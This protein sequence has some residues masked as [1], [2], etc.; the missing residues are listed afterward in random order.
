MSAP[1]RPQASSRRSAQHEGTAVSA[2][3]Q[4]RLNMASAAQIAEHLRRGDA[5]FVPHLSSRVEIDAYALKMGCK[6]TRFEAWSDGTLVGL[7]AAYCNDLD[8][9]LAYITSVSVLRA[10]NGKGIAARLLAQCVE[11]AKVSGL[12]QICLEVA[13]TNTP[14]IKLYEKTGFVVSQTN[15]PFIGMKLGLERG[16]IHDQPA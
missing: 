16:E 12:R 1:G 15:A 8:R 14:A 13:S 2:P 11:H 10:W 6:A 9:Q 3:I 4:F 7:V 5:D